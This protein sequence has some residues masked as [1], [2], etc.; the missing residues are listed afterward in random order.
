MANLRGIKKDIAYLVG[1]VI[2]NA[3]LAFYFQGEA[4][5]K[6]LCEVIEK[7]IDLHNNLIERANHPA[8]KHNSK[9]VRKHY[10]AIKTD[11]MVGVDGLFNDIST[12]CSK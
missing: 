2:S 6:P 3:N 7:S 9:L 1:E 11:L 10:S 4:A 12:I 5:Q 8:E